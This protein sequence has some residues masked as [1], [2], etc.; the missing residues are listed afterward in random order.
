MRI[1]TVVRSAWSHGAH[2]AATW[3]SQSLCGITFTI[4][5][6]LST[7]N[8]HF[9]R[10]TPKARWPS[11]LGYPM[12]SF[13]SET[14]IAKFGADLMSTLRLLNLSEAIKDK[15]FNP[16]LVETSGSVN[17]VN[18]VCRVLL[19]G[20]ELSSKRLTIAGKERGY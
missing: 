19:L 7:A 20:R 3:T 13:K 11:F 2:V 18:V 4:L 16:F 12:T 10:D 6:C 14:N 1:Y 17:V 15:D 9:N 5:T 8:M